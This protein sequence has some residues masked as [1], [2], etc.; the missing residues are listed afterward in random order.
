MILYDDKNI[1]IILKVISFRL[2]VSLD[3]LTSHVGDI[4]VVLLDLEHY[5]KV[6]SM[7]H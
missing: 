3:L 2:S 7:S 5:L 4:E 6:I 1:S